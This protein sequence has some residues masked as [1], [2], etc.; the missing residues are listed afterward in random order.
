MMN[1]KCNSIIHCKL[2]SWRLTPILHTNIVIQK[3]ELNSSRNKHL[4]Y[5]MYERVMAY[6]KLELYILEGRK[7]TKQKE[8][9][10]P[11]SSTL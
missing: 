6:W 5:V 2:N 3:L 10:Q 7:T 9:R 1:K 11:N 8:E 4:P